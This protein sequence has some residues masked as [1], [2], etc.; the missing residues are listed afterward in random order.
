MFRI[1]PAWLR[2]TTHG[3]DFSQGLDGWS[4]FKSY[5]PAATWRRARVAGAERIAHPSKRG[6]WVLHVRRPDE[7]AGDGAAWNFPSGRTGSVTLRIRLNKGFAGG[8]VTLTDRFIY[9]DD[10][11]LDKVAFALALPVDGRIGP[12]A[13]LT[14]DE[15]HTL[16]LAWK[17]EHKP[18]RGGWPGECVVSLDGRQALTLPQLNRAKAGLSY[19]RLHSTAPGID[20]AGFLV[21]RVSA[22][23]ESMTTNRLQPKPRGDSCRLAWR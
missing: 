23:I 8:L 18:P 20:N 10:A 15:W 19:L 12:D 17:V 7:K 6:A 2:L 16:K 4:V 1:D 22:E 3:D 14:S 11:D 21:E 5:G 13:K 9:P